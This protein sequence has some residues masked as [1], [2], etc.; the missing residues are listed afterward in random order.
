MSPSRVGNTP[1]VNSSYL[2]GNEGY[3]IAGVAFLALDRHRPSVARNVESNVSTQNIISR[4]VGA[5][6]SRVSS[7][8]HRL[9]AI[10]E[11]I[12]NERKSNR[13]EHGSDY[14]DKPVRYMSLAKT[15]Y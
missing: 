14:P 9:A 5:I 11:P 1:T 3:R 8:Q 12:V 4:L 10:L 6:H 15:I 2:C 7:H 13:S